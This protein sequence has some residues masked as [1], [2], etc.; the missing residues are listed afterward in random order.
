MLPQQTMSDRYLVDSVSMLV[1]DMIVSTFYWQVAST[2]AYEA[3]VGVIGKFT[4]ISRDWSS[5][6]QAKK[7]AE[8]ATNLFWRY[9]DQDND[10]VKLLTIK[11]LRAANCKFAV[12]RDNLTGRWTIA[13]VMPRG[14]SW[15]D[16]GLSFAD[17]ESA[18]SM[19]GGTNRT[20]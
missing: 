13:Y 19:I 11:K 17:E 15:L 8:F 14:A 20:K 7:A 4:L 12:T 2:G 6:D 3:E 10:S 18:R 5:L 16:T 9:F 1:G